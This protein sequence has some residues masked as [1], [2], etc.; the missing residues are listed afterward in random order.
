MDETQRPDGIVLTEAAE[1]QPPPALDRDRASLLGA[2]GAVFRRHPGQG[3]GR[4]HPAACEGDGSRRTRP[5]LTSS[6][7]AAKP[8][9]G[10]DA[11][12]AAC[13]RPGRGADGR[14]GLRRR[15]RSTTGSAA[16]PASTA[17]RRS[18]TQL[19]SRRP[20]AARSPSASTPMSAPGL[21][22]KFEPEQTE[23]ECRSARSHRR[24]YTV[25]NHVGTRRRRAARPTTSRR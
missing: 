15:A 2:R 23:I 25:T 3:T 6:A 21:P 4:A 18:P 16:S 1:A 24:I 12:V 11:A 13:V 10:R 19:P 14:R 8:R 17:P 20:L 5:P 7:P 9:I 22:W